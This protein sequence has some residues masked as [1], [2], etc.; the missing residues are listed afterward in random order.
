LLP[1]SLRKYAFQSKAPTAIGTRRSSQC[2][3]HK[4]TLMLDNRSHLFNWTVKPRAR[5]RLSPIFIA[6]TRRRPIAIGLAGPAYQQ[7]VAARLY[8]AIVKYSKIRSCD[9]DLWPMT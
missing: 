3:S 7:P 8:V 6:M 2:S 9:L 1:T 5:L 4:P